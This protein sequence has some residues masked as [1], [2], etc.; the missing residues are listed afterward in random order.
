MN[1]SV[2]FNRKVT[3]CGRSLINVADVASKL[4]YL[5]AP[6]GTFIDVDEI[7]EYPLNRIVIITT[8]TQGEPMSALSRMAASEHKKS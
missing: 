2:Q 6:E 5:T 1:A 7:D 3:V 8:G 4:G